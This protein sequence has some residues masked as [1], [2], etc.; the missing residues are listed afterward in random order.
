MARSVKKTYFFSASLSREEITL[1]V[2]SLVLLALY[3]YY[4]GSPIFQAHASV[5]EATVDGALAAPLRAGAHLPRGEVQHSGGKEEQ[6]KEEKGWYKK[7]L[8][9]QEVITHFM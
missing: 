5:P 1:D 6:S 4:I 8:C 9:V 3:I 2:H 7:I